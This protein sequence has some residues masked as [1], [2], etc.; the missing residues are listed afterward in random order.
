MQSI[1]FSPE[2]KIIGHILLDH[3]L[4]YALTVATDVHVVYL[5]Q[6]WRTVSKIKED[7]HSI[8]DDVPLVSVYTTRDVHVRG[9][10]ISDVFL[11]KEIRATD[12][13]KESIPRAHR[14]PTLTSSPQGKKR[15]QSTGESKPASH[16]EKLEYVDDDDDKGVEKVDA[17]EGEELI[18]TN[19]KPCIAA[20]IIQDRDAFHYEVP[21]LVSQEFNAQAPKIIEDL[22]KNYIQSNVI[23]VHPTTTTSIKTTSSADLQ[24][25]LYF[26]MKRKETVIDEDEVILK[27]GTLKL[28]I[29]IQD[30]DKRVP[31]IFDYERMR[32]TVSLKILSRTR[33]LDN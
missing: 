3:P 9:M 13:L 4:S 32:A 22:F 27:D 26:K 8:K 31:T 23:K 7:Y 1:P 24:Q 11:T 6:F 17:E 16:K 21:D 12:D 15:K 33:K 14:T 2:C 29:E 19:L 25:Q 28:I 10:L 18:E 20:T 5:Q 30:V